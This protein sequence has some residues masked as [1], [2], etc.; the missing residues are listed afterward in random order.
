MWGWG[1]EEGERA[2]LQPPSPLGPLKPYRL[3]PVSQFPPTVPAFG[4]CQFVPLPAYPSL[5]L[6]LRCELNRGQK[7]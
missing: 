2:W 5:L 3:E 4:R 1:A 6:F 7:S